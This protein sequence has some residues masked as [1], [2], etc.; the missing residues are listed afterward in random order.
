MFVVGR[1]ARMARVKALRWTVGSVL[2][3]GILAALSPQEQEFYRK[4]ST[5]VG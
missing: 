5:C 2:Q 1:N 4:Y 3:P